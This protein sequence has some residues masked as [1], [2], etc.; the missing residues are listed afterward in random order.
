M[1]YRDIIK[2]P[3]EEE[4]FL[5]LA[6]QGGVSPDQLVN[7]RSKVFKDLKIDLQELSPEGVA[8]VINENP[9]AMIRPLFS[10]AKSLVVGFDPDSVKKMLRL[11]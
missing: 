7:R 4:E 5:T 11:T 9:K 10:D 6:R 1:E 3:L 2:Q 8:R